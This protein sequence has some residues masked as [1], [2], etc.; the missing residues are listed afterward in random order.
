[1]YYG[2]E[3][4]FAE[5]EAKTVLNFEMDM[6]KVISADLKLSLG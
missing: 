2:A 5:T 1:V 3:R 6:A 4:F